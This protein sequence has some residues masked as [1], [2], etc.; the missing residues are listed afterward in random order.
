VSQYVQQVLVVV[1]VDCS[2]TCHQ[3]K[4]ADNHALICRRQEGLKKLEI[5]LKQAK[6]NAYSKQ[7]EALQ[8]QVR[9]AELQSSK[10][11]SSS[12]GPSS[13]N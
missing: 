8:L 9:L 6:E 10:Q 5:E 12:S 3:C 4:G 2:G 7:I 11:P 13:F 1:D